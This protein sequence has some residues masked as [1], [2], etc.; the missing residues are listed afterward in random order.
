[1]SVT[2]SSLG[3]PWEGAWEPAAEGRHGLV[4]ITQG[5]YCIIEGGKDRKPAQ[6]QPPSEAEAAALFRSLVAAGGTFAA[7]PSEGGW[8]H[9]LTPTISRNPWAE[10]KGLRMAVQVDGDKATFQDVRA[11]GTL[12][13]GASYRRVSQP[14]TAA[15]AGAWEYLSERRNGLLLQSDGYYTLIETNKDRPRPDR[16]STQIGD[17]EVAQ[18]YAGLS[19][20][21]GTYTISSSTMT[22]V[23]MVAL[24]P[25]LQG[26]EFPVE[27]KMDRDTLRRF[28]PRPDGTTTEAVWRRIG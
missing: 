12:A 5:H 2:K 7:S 27:F 22:R 16:P 14:G 25:D 18:L 20:Q 13:E 3:Q 17:A 8:M 19:V 23:P 26:R 28:L 9:E 11:D 15:L 21:A 6:S 10:G 4:L 24:N 1:M